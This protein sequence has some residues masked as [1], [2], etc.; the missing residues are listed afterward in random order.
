M[1]SFHRCLVERLILMTHF[2]FTFSPQSYLMMLA[3]QMGSSI[4]IVVQPPPFKCNAFALQISRVSSNVNKGKQRQESR[5]ESCNALEYTRPTHG[6]ASGKGVNIERAAQEDCYYQPFLKLTHRCD[7][8]DLSNKNDELRAELL[9]Y[10][11]YLT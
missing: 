6:L 2:R 10:L 8:Q 5:H 9:R 7:S 1:C 11:F 3:E 4:F